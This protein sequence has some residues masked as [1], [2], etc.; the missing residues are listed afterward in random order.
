[1]VE[2]SA[3]I[4]IAYGVLSLSYGFALG[5]PLSAVR[6][7]APQAPRHLVIAHLAAIIQGAVH[8]G[9]SV[10]IQFSTLPEPI[11]IAASSL[12]VAG[13]ASFTAGATV[14]WLQGIGDH[15]AKR[16]LGWKMLSVSGVLHIAG[17]SIVLVGV[18][19][20]LW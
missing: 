6:M 12:L 19:A 11:E 17:I 7:N 3:K 8:L 5:I 4:L 9:L 13:S 18:A 14:N 1:M 15:F 2:T 16:S 10:A 20:A